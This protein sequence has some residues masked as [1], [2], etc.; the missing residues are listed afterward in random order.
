MSRISATYF[1]FSIVEGGG[2]IYNHYVYT[3]TIQG[4]AE[5]SYV[6]SYL[7]QKKFCDGS[8]ACT[9]FPLGSLQIPHV[10]MVYHDYTYFSR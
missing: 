8:E 1:D 3:Y 5:P 9:F 6:C 4:G 10:P 2:R 7:L